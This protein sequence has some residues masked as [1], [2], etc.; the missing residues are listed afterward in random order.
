[1]YAAAIQGLHG[2]LGRTRIVILDKS[3]VESLGLG[4]EQHF[5]VSKYCS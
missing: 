2:T 1:M 4:G 3:I 5:I